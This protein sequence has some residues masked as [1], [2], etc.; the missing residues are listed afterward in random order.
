MANRNEVTTGIGLRM[1]RV[2]L[3][4]TDNL[5]DVPAG[6][7]AG[8]YYNGLR[9]GG[10]QALTVTIPP[11]NRVVARGDDRAYHTF[12]L[13]PT[14]APSG[15]LRV[16]KTDMSVIA[17]LTGVIVFGTS[18]LRKIGFGS[19]AQ[20]D[21]PAVIMWGSRLG[22]DSDQGSTNFGTQIWETYIFLNAVASP[23]PSSMED[24]TVSELTYA[25]AANDSGVDEMGTTFTAVTHGFTKTPFL[26]LITYGKFML[27][28]FIAT[29]AQ[30]A[31]TLSQGDTVNTSD[32]VFVSVNGVQLATDAYSETGGVVTLDTPATASDKVLIAYGYD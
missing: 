15:E 6:W 12:Q 4:D 18:P 9:V 7:T 14:E 1:V 23:S 31:F 25:V 28:A 10:A 21:E 13:P 29:A 16:S 11:P 32:Q 17:L 26:L 8:T 2:A 20:G 19:D 3:R 5:I 30:T 22:I 27:D 24:Q